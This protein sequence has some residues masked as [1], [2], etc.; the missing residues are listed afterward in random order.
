VLSAAHR[1]LDGDDAPARRQVRATRAIRARVKELLDLCLTPRQIARELAV[2]MGTVRRAI[3]RL[4]GRT[5]RDSR[6]YTDAERGHH[7]RL[8]DRAAERLVW[9]KLTDERGAPILDT[10]GN[11]IS[12]ETTEAHISQLV[13]VWE[14]RDQ[15]LKPVKDHG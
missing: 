15:L 11:P 3:A 7:L 8:L 6:K 4:D 12:I 9:P 14:N 5:I 13:K 10:E 2:P 1:K